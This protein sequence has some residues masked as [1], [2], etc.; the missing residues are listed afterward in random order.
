MT[1][2]INIETRV[3]ND[4]SC[5]YSS[6][7]DLD[8]INVSG[9]VE[10]SDMEKSGLGAFGFELNLWTNDAFSQ[11]ITADNHRVGETLFFSVT[12]NPVL[13]NVVFR[14]SKCSVFNS[15]REHEYVLF[16]GM[17]DQFDPFVET[18]RYRPL[19]SDDNGET[20]ASDVVDRYSYTVFE[21]L[22]DTNSTIHI[23]CSIQAQLEK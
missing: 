19:Y 6:V 23:D 16:D 5:V 18:T 14:T 17:L 21:F 10:R 1:A 11:A 12:Q 13:S 4:F 22:E 20:C 8:D 9:Q 15:N 3:S 7:L 2:I